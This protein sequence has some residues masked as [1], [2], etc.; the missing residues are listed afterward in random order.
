MKKTQ[1]AL[2][3]FLSLLLSFF[4]F[5]VY[6][7]NFDNKEE[8]YKFKSENYLREYYNSMIKRNYIISFD[9]MIESTRFNYF[10]SFC[11]YDKDFLF[12]G[13]RELKDNKEIKPWFENLNFVEI[14]NEL[15]D[16]L[17]NLDFNFS[18]LNFYKSVILNSSFYLDSYDYQIMPSKKFFVKNFIVVEER[19]PYEVKCYYK[20]YVK[21][22]SLFLPNLL[23]NAVYLIELPIYNC[24][25]KKIENKD[26]DFFKDKTIIY[27]DNIIYF[28]TLYFNS[29]SF[30]KSHIESFKEEIQEFI[31]SNEEVKKNLLLFGKSE[32]KDYSNLNFQDYPKFYISFEDEKVV[33]YVPTKNFIILENNS[34]KYLISYFIKK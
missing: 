1:L 17:K 32:I 7:I 27:L 22:D 8:N 18:V 16:C 24:F 10:T 33:V 28:K 6:K 9:F 26:L 21:F 15:K 30:E 25:Y 14:E 34:K 19:K 3:V 4:V 31:N 20:Y 11:N 5:L 2:F 29:F 13:A 23:D 12:F